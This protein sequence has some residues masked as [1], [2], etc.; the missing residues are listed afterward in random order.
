MKPHNTVTPTAS[1]ATFR[2]RVR[3]D[4]GN[5]SSAGQPSG[6]LAGVEAPRRGL[7]PSAATRKLID[8]LYFISGRSGL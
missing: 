4:A 2:S 3:R 7:P 8:F 5:R 1:S 6:L